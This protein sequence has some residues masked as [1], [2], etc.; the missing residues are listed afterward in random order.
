MK[1]G[2][3][4]ERGINKKMQTTGRKE[5]ETKYWRRKQSEEERK[6]RD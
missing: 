3:T 6:R 4:K 2:R 1:D 5:A